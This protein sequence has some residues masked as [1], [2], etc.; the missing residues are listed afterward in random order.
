MVP[1]LT[2]LHARVLDYTTND[3]WRNER[4]YNSEQGINASTRSCSEI[5]VG[6]AA[7]NHVLVRVYS[8][9]ELA[10][11]RVPRTKHTTFEHQVL[12]QPLIFA[13]HLGVH[14]APAN[15]TGSC[16]HTTCVTQ[17]CAS[18][19]NNTTSVGLLERPRRCASTSSVHIENSFLANTGT[20]VLRQ[21]PVEGA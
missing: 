1:I 20:F 16:V 5:G 13:H 8:T 15:T 10:P 3:G 12:Y 19:P 7:G 9:H 6:T 18:M 21:G 2:F 17:T 4:G 14:T 11:W